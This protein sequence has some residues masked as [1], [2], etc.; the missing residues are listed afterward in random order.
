MSPFRLIRWLVGGLF[1]KL[2]E[3]RY[4]DPNGV[5]DRCRRC[6]EHGRRRCSPGVG[7]IYVSNP[8]NHI[9]PSPS[10]SSGWTVRDDVHHP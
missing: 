2:E 4:D 3:R 1:L 10:C 9:E 5:Y 8:T 7:C 6:P